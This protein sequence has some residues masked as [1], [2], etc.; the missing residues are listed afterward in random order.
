MT[1][2]TNVVRHLSELQE[3]PWIFTFEN[4][5]D[6]GGIVSVPSVMSGY[7]ID[8]PPRLPAQAQWL[9]T[10]APTMKACA[11]HAWALEPEA[12]ERLK[13]R[14]Q[15]QVEFEKSGLKATGCESRV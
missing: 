13:G 12:W 3:E 2:E 4:L 11:G 1:R 5:S 7:P 14:I 8:W 9:Q 6:G 15:D 10:F